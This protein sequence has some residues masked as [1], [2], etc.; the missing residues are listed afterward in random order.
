MYGLLGAGLGDSSEQ[1]QFQMPFPEVR[2][3]ADSLLGSSL[4]EFWSDL[5]AQ[6]AEAKLRIARY[7][8]Q[9]QQDTGDQYMSS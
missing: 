1:A 9:R 4:L 7:I 8:I 6:L 2:G 5:R 3:W